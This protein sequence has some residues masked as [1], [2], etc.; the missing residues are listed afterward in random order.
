MK[1]A[2]L[3]IVAG[4]TVLFLLS[5]AVL[6]PRGPSI[7]YVVGT[8]SDLRGDVRR[9]IQGFNDDG[10]SIILAEIA[11]EDVEYY[12]FINQRGLRKCDVRQSTAFAADLRWW[13][14]VAFDKSQVYGNSEPSNQLLVTRQNHHM[15]VRRVFHRPPGG[16]RLE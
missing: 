11:V 1:R 10:A 9:V 2:I 12:R 16:D 3:L 4:L 15:Y 5:I 7:E 13:D 8:G 14:G 6:V